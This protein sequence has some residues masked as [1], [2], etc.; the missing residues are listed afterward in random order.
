MEIGRILMDYAFREW[1]A[2]NC[3]LVVQ[4]PGRVHS[5]SSARFW[6][7]VF[8]LELNLTSVLYLL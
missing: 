3:R 6:T 1:M 4:S 7:F 5:L 2:W 8:T